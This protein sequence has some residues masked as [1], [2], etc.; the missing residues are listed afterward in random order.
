[1]SLSQDDLEHYIKLLRW[2][3]IRQSND[4]RAQRI[5]LEERITSLEWENAA[6]KILV[7]MYKPQPLI[8]VNRQPY[9]I[10]S[11]PENDHF[12]AGAP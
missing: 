11:T 8:Q 1:M 3:S 4:E 10:P 2:E 9:K 12:L 5:G 6:L 7:R